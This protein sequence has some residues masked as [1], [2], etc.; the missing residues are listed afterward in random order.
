M[1][2]IAGG[3]GVGLANYVAEAVAMVLCIKLEEQGIIQRF[4]PGT[5]PFAEHPSSNILAVGLPYIPLYYAISQT[6]A[7]GFGHSAELDFNVLRVWRFIVIAML[8]HDAWFF[9]LH[10]LFHKVRRL[11]R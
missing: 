10:T 4:I 7:K 9:G 3:L 5:A 2:G 1:V 6:W 11:Y 8:C